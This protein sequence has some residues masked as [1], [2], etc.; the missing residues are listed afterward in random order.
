MS[1]LASKMTVTTIDV[2]PIDIIVSFLW[3]R[4]TLQSE[5]PIKNYDRLNL[6]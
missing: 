3:S 4:R 1:F 2:N 5:F 6:R